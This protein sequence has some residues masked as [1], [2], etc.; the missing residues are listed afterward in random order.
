MKWLA[1]LIIFCSFS[2]V[3]S[4]SRDNND[5]TH[6]DQPFLLGDWYL[7]N[8]EPDNETDSFLAIK[9][10]LESNYTFSIDIQKSDYSVEHWSGLFSANE[11]TL[12]LGLNSE[13]PQIYDYQSNHNKLN[14][15]GVLFTK[16][17]SNGLA[18]IWSSVTVSGDDKQAKIINQMDLILQPDFVFT[19][20]V[21][22]D[23]GDEAIHSGVYYTEDDHLVLLY[24]NGEHDTTYTLTEDELTLEVEDG[25][26]FAVLNRIR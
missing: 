25:D 12:I 2:V 10:S 15:N 7:V 9:L 4:P 11:E 3:S 14:L 16:A 5:L 21:R 23:A 17:L 19:F 22:S 24:Q 1:M 26:M 8:P 6:F 20:R 18:G 13:D